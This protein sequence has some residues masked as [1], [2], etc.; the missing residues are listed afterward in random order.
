MRVLNKLGKPVLFLCFI[1]FSIN[2]KL[3]V[4]AAEGSV[5]FGSESYSWY[6]E[7][8]CPIG[9]YIESQTPIAVYE[10]CLEYDPA[11]LEY[12]NG[13]A[14]IIDNKIYLR[15]NGTELRYKNM[16]HFKPLAEG[17]TSIQVV[18]AQAVTA[19]DI[20]G[21]N[22]SQNIDMTL[23]QAAPVT[24][25]Q[26]VS[27]EIVSI[28]TSPAALENFQPDVKEY[29][30]TVEAETANLNVEYT[31]LDEN[32]SV[33]LSDT[34]LADGENIITLSVQGT[35]G[36]NVYTFY[37]H[38]K[39][40]E[41]ESTVPTD[42]E[43]TEGPVVV[44]P[45]DTGPAETKASEEV[46]AVS[47]NSIPENISDE[48]EPALGDSMDMSLII[49]SAACIIL[50]LQHYAMKIQKILEKKEK[51]NGE[52]SEAWQDETLHIINFEKTVIEAAHITMQFRMAQDEMSS[53]KEYFI[54]ILKRQNKY[55]ML[56]VLKDISFEVKQG[57]VVGI[58]GTNGSGK[59]TLL[60]IISG[61]LTPTSGNVTVDRSKVQ[62]LTLGT[63]FD[64]ELTARENVYLNG[65]II[66]YSKAY[67]DE[68]YDDI[69]EFAELNGFM[70]E[71]MK[72]FST[73]MVT[74][75][76]FAIATM[77]DTP[78]I[79]ILDEVLSVGDMF[80]KQKSEKRIKEMIHSGATVLM[81]SHGVETILKNCNKVIW[82]EK[83]ILKMAGD[84]RDVCDA[85]KN[86]TK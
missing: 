49:A 31:L 60:K 42:T 18:S 38:R 51:K 8:T 80:F 54:K 61:A 6:T 55:R 40:H 23:L 77:Q 28:Q 20:S 16:L 4:A 59:S 85:Y 69:V 10:I 1:L 57:D 79:L 82:I 56:T 30:L 47:E 86:Y 33:S 24:I 7:E 34:K 48:H 15:G 64:M 12:L 29:S 39:E 35:E 76:G 52:E 5:V 73:G 68:K 3:D 44:P 45:S 26:F 81:V 13:A 21:G 22:A 32:A 72:N 67:I 53:L 27:N 46:P 11:M 2:R 17:T 58:I 19:E 25:R 37:V 63:G 14:E 36:N 41:Q 50:L 70:E 9:V 74:R 65:A 84:P 71:R 75:L 62:M 66:G 78:E 43:P 83:G